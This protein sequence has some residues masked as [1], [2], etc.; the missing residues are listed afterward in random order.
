MTQNGTEKNSDS[1]PSYMDGIDNPALHQTEYQHPAIVY[2][3]SEYDDI[4]RFLTYNFTFAS[5]IRDGCEEMHSQF[6]LVI[7]FYS[8]SIK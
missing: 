2:G 3:K 8:S 4:S 6:Y 5:G 7:V 1:A